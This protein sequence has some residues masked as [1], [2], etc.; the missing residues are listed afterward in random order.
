MCKVNDM[1][2]FMIVNSHLIHLETEQQFIMAIR[3]LTHKPI[4]EPKLPTYENWCKVIE[5]VDNEK[6]SDTES[7][8]YCNSKIEQANN[9]SNNIFDNIDDLNKHNISCSCYFC[10]ELHG[11]KI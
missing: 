1:S 7:S 10:K 2:F 3:S 8:I 9:K 6:L 11:I 4:K 5:T